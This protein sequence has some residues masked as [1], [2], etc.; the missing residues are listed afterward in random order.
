MQV[1]IEPSGCRE[2][3]RDEKKGRHRA[4]L[5]DSIRQGRQ[6]FFSGASKGGVK[7]ISSKIV[8]YLGGCQNY[9]PFLDPYYNVAPNI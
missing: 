7:E 4:P 3:Y 2:I 6:R 9:G 5:E 8:E 1:V